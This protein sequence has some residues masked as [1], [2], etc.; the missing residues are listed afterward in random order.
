MNEKDFSNRITAHLDHGTAGL[1]AGTAYR[2]Q[3]AREA[4]MARF[5]DPRR[6][7]ELG[8]A[9]AGGGTFGNARH[10]LTDIRLWVGVLAIVGCVFYYQQWQSMQQSSQLVRDITDTDAAILTSDLPI[11]A[12]VD[13]GFQNW[14]KRSEP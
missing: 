13:T 12:Y 3:L 14:L 8:L 2:L 5:S 1:K 9:G 6:A 11:E 4:A 7:A 10:L